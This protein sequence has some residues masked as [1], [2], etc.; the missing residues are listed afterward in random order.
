LLF[1]SLGNGQ[2]ADVARPLGCDVIED[3]RAVAV[4]DL[5]QDGRLDIVI[6]NN[7]DPPAILLNR[8]GATGNWVRMSLVGVKPSN[9]DAL[10]A[11]ATLAL[12]VQGRPRTLTRWVEAGSGYS[13]QS[14]MTLHFGLADAE[15]IQS[16]EIVWP[17]GSKQSFP[18]DR[19]KTAVNG[20]IRIEQGSDDAAVIVPS[21]E[22][23]EASTA[24][25]AP[26][27]AGSFEPAKGT[28]GQPL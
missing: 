3:S 23:P 4:A 12:E 14:D 28:K 25:P 20:T 6:A 26:K 19:L 1:E 21:S 18:G 16:L 8:L 27:S 13:S 15:R 17:D 9:R 10:G 11:K 2:F 22:P 7:D 5:N 24:S